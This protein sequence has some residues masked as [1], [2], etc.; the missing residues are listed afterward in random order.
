MG[1][2]GVN[3]RRG[4]P[5][6]CFEPAST[7]QGR[8]NAGRP[9]DDN[10]QPYGPA[11]P[12]IEQVLQRELPAAGPQA[13]EDRSW[14]REWEHEARDFHEWQTTLWSG[15]AVP[16]VGRLIS[17]VLAIHVAVKKRE[18]EA[19]AHNI[20]YEPA[21][22]FALARESAALARNSLPTATPEELKNVRVT[23]ASS[24]PGPMRWGFCSVL[25][26]KR[27]LGRNS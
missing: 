9:G 10:D 7:V 21:R 3:E 16:N 26:P 4:G 5:K 25:Q 6:E 27:S 8:M 24:E 23:K 18:F 20:H 11:T 13:V 19:H 17:W 12:E 22:L 15:L 2:H 1:S 14:L